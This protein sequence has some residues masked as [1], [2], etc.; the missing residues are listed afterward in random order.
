MCPAS[1]SPAEEDHKPAAGV[2][3]LAGGLPVAA[4]SV[5]R[6]RAI[7]VAKDPV[8]GPA[9]PDPAPTAPA[10]ERE[11]RKERGRS[12]GATLRCSVGRTAGPPAVAAPKSRRMQPEEVLQ[13]E[14][15]FE[16]CLPAFAVP[17]TTDVHL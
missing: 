7:P 16:S 1:K 14:K 6:H 9:R 15:R 4:A 11:P 8:A 5:R 3:P 17:D 12:Y 13:G 10:P 2:E